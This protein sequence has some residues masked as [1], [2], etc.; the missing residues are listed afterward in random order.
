[1]G[2]LKKSGPIWFSC[3][4][5]NFLLDAVGDIQGDSVPWAL[6]CFDST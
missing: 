5:R 3:F 6:Y 2:P 4:V 1:M